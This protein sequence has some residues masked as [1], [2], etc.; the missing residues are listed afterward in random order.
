M[1]LT[2]LLIFI[3]FCNAVSAD[4][5]LPPATTM[6]CTLRYEELKKNVADGDYI[7]YRKWYSLNSPSVKPQVDAMVADYYSFIG[8]QLPTSD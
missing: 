8:R 6:Q 7:E 2:E 4:I 3:G 5:A 1:G